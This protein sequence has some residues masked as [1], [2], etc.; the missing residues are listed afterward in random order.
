VEAEPWRSHASQQKKNK[1]TENYKTKLILHHAI[2]RALGKEQAR[3][4]PVTVSN[5]YGK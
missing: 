3:K 1:M 5:K 4:P 2:V